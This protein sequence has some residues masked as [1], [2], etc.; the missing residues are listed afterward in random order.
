MG[1]MRKIRRHWIIAAIIAAGA[2]APL[3]AAGAEQELPRA[4]SGRS[5]TA[6]AHQPL[7]EP[8]AGVITLLGWFGDDVPRFEVVNVKP[9]NTAA[10]VE[11]WVRFVDGVAIPIIYVRADTAVY[12][13]AAAKNYQALVRLAGILA[14]ERWHLRHGRDEVGAY[15]AQLSTMEYLHADT[16]HLAAVRMALRRLRNEAKKKTR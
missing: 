7:P 8:L 2:G 6:A 5:G 11:A 9:A 14:H 13:D 16:V 1:A 3:R 10:N 12:R 15:E 4:T